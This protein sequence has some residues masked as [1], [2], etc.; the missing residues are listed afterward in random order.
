MPLSDSAKAQDESAAILRRAGLVWV[1]DN[2]RIEQGGRLEGVL[3]E[4]IRPDQSALRLIQ[5]SMRFERV[6]HLFGARLED[7]EQIS[8][9]AIKIFEHIAQLMRG[10]FGIKS[11]NSADDMV[12]S[13]LVGGV[14]VPGFSRWLER[15]DDDSGGIR[16]QIQA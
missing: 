5:F 6:F 3:V 7:I 16:A 15:S 10:S 13:D 4:K 8:V 9:T 14:E 11:K 2:A 12:G 1:S